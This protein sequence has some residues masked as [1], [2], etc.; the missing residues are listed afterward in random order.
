MT[1]FAAGPVAT[2][3]PDAAPAPRRI[4][5]HFETAGPQTPD[6]RRAMRAAWLLLALGFGGTLAWAAITPIERAVLARGSLVAEGRRKSI[7]LAE[8]G[9]LQDLLVREGQRVQAGEVLLRLDPTNAEA[10]AVQAR[11][12]ARTLAARTARLVAEQQDSRQFEIPPGIRQ[13]AATDPALAAILLAEG[14]LFQARWQAFDSNQRVYERRAAVPREQLLAAGAQR[15]AAAARQASVRADLAGLRPLAQQGFARMREVREL[16]RLEAQARGDMGLHAA[17]E[18]QF[19]QSIA[20]AEAELATLRLTR[21]QE[22]A[23]ELQAA[24][25]QALEAEQRLLAA[26]NTRTRRDLVAPEAGIVTDIRFVTP[27]SSITEGQPVLD[28][29]PIGDRLVVEA[30]IAPN[31]VEQVQPGQRVNIRLTALRQRTTPLLAGTLTYVSADRQ[32]DAQGQPFFLA[33]AEINPGELSRIARLRLTP[34]MP[35]EVFVL[36]ETRSALAYL[37]SPI[38]DSLRRALRD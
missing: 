14:R 28:L 35:T 15:A 24:Q 26:E 38:R 9:I 2:R 32:A 29:V 13:A 20:Q 8:P 18:A 17:Q 25:Q 5:L 34:G 37:V 33:R 27:G 1:R 7:M 11:A 3:R 36:G 31:D 19:R 12:L 4:A 23:G 10:T 6:L 21:A 16:E 30:R 22:I